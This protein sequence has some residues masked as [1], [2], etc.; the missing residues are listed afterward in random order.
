[1]YAYHALLGRPRSGCVMDH[2]Y[3]GKEY[4]EAEV[5]SALERRGLRYRHFTDETR[6]LD[7]TVDDLAA[8]K[9][10]GWY[11]GRFE[12]GPRALGNRS[13]LGDPRRAEMKDIV[14]TK[15][16]FRE[17]YRPFA[18]SVL[19][20]ESERY[21]ELPESARHDPARFMLLVVP[22]RNDGVPA[23]THVDGSARLQ[24]VFRD[25]NPRY[26]EL[27]RRF[28]ELSGVPV[29]LNTSFNL[30][31]EPIVTTPDN[32]MNTFF[33]SEMDTLVLGNHIVHKSENA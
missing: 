29:L 3:W 30:K 12:W 27:I 4:G 6:L 33:A 14:N 13:I 7:A 17:P 2:A 21:F 9:V 10:I 19:V 5:R 20:G 25:T 24:T 16:K 8:G 22:V 26:Y 1:L 18:P 28:G 11:Q 31:G 15:I 23:V 32:A